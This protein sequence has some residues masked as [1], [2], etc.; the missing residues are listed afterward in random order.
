MRKVTIQAFATLDGVVQAPGGPDEDRD[1]GFP[2]GGWS[3]PYWDEAM[4]AAMDATIATPQ[5][6]L[7][8]RRTYDIF[9]AHWPR[10]GDEEPMARHLNAATKYV[11][12]HRP[13][14]LGWGPHV[15][16]GPDVAAHVAALK[17]EDGPDL[18][19]MGSSG[20]VQTLFSAGLV[21][22][23]FLM[24]F[25]LVLGT[26]K[27][28]FGAGTVPAGYALVETR[29]SS[30]GVSMTRWRAAPLRPAGSFAL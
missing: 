14:S 3:V 25:P 11:A 13:E 26:G 15:A 4:G 17:R 7:L 9:A 29:M 24:V 20:L 18:V 30:T 22:E 23:M 28:L 10:V 8:G 19:V 12:T 5:D 2:H 6:L 1:G 16:L 27:R 21:D